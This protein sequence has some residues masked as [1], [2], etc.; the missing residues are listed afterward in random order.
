MKHIILWCSPGFGVAD[1]WL[2]VLKKLKQKEDVKID[3]VFPELSSLRLEDKNSDLFKI[4]EEF[5]DEVIY[6]GYSGRWFVAPSLIKAHNAIKFNNF[7][8][9]MTLIS[10]RLSKGKLSNIFFLK[11]V[12]NL[13]S[14]ISKCNFLIKESFSNVALFDL[15][16]FQ[17]VDGV[18]CDIIFENKGVNRELRT[19]LKD[20][21]KFS[22]YHGL[23]A[24]WVTSSFNCNKN[25]KQRSDVTVYSMSKLESDGYI[26]CIG[27]LKEN[28]I[29][30][31]IPRHDKDWIEFITNRLSPYEE[32]EFEPYVFLIGRPASAYNTVERKKN[33]LRD[34]YNKVCINQNLKIIVKSH[35]KE[36][37][38]GVDG[39]IY[40]QALGKKNYGKTWIYSNKHPFVLGKKAVF[41]VSF[42]SGVS[43]DMLAINKPTIEYLNLTN[44]NAY[45]NDNSFRD[46]YGDPVFELRYVNLVLGASS[47][48][49]F[50]EHVDSIMNQYNSTTLSLSSKYQEYFDPLINASEIVAKDIYKKI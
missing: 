22:M 14:V 10:R 47:N 20:I 23:T 2:P 15:N 25:V 6:K 49:K 38:H 26:D 16:L 37:L 18:L 33:A 12:G 3:F 11:I 36:S 9:K 46:E 45:D 42:Y 40:T 28:I 30:V 41:S 13:L 50:S 44:L 7:D 27:V 24:T 32:D 39:E 35:P 17:N 29:R 5:L 31:G 43:M 34:I 19:E 8:E 1:I 4:S 48:E 21:Q